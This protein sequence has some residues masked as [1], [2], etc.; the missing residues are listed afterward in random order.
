M[1]KKF[2]KF[3]VV[4]VA[5]F[6]GYKA[7]EVYALMQFGKNF[8]SCGLREKVCPLIAQR[9]NAMQVGAAFNETLR[10]VADRQ[11][12]IEALVLPVSKQISMSNLEGKVP[13][14]E[15]EQLCA[16]QR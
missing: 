1:L 14:A 13:Y 4:L 7:A 15:A 5:M 12:F 2:F 16:A 8:E 6:G 9:A 11:S 10:C 3:A